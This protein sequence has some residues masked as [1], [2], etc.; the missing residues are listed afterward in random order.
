MAIAHGM[1]AI[2]RRTALHIY[3]LCYQQDQTQDL[4]LVDIVCSINISSQVFI[5]PVISPFPT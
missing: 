4:E 1:H 2:A 5:Q 3:Y